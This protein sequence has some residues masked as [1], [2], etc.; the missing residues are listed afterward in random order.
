MTIRLPFLAAAAVLVLA[1]S[2]PAQEQYKQPR[3]EDGQPDIQGIWT[4]YTITPFERPA[5]WA[6]KATLT[7]EEVKAYEEETAKRAAG[8]PPKGGGVGGDTWL[9]PGN[10][11]LYGGQTAM[12]VDPPDGRVPVKPEAEQHRQFMLAHS[13][14][15]W[16]YMSVWDRCLTRGVPGGMFPGNNDNAYQIYQTPGFVVV[17][18]EMIHEAHIIPLD[19]GKSAH[20]PDSV[21]QLNGDSHG[22][23]D[24]NTLIVETTN[25]DGITQIATSAVQGRLRAM[26]MSKSTHVTE[27]FTRINETVLNYEVTIDDPET[28]SRPWT[29]RIPLNGEP[30]YRIFEVACHEGNTATEM[31]LK[32]ARAQEK[33]ASGSR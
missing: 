22:R 7:P 17:F 32:G 8:Y 2:A 9:D 18:Y 20:L 1:G 5:R 6:D 10:K 26:P 3:T 11:M 12:V 24:G 21:R 33:A 29:A 25:Y 15:S 4:S 28:Y 19:L 14:D 27:K 16:E 23:W 13:A 31:T 30:N